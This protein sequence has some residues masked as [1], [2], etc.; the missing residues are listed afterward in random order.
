MWQVTLVETAYRLQQKLGRLQNPEKSRRVNLNRNN[1]VWLDAFKFTGV[2]A[3]TSTRDKPAPHKN[4]HIF[5]GGGGGGGGGK[6]KESG[7]GYGLGLGLA[8]KHI[9]RIRMNSKG[10][11][12]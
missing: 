7:G 5:E 1:D 12:W 4:Y 9:R 6:E 2:F 3:N 11:S 10:Y 8:L